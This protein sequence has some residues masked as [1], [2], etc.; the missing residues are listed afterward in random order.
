MAKIVITLPRSS[1]RLHVEFRTVGCGF[2]SSKDSIFIYIVLYENCIFRLKLILKID[3]LIAIYCC[4]YPSL[5]LYVISLVYHS[6]L[7]ACF[8]IP[9]SEC[10][11]KKTENDT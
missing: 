5:F 4:T 10:S 3:I 1:V 8:A 7:K 6:T 11:Y 2:E 9:K